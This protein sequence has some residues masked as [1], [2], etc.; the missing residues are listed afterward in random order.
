MLLVHRYADGVEAALSGDV[1]PDELTVL[2][3]SLARRGVDTE[4]GAL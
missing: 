2:A 3:A 4:V 1:S